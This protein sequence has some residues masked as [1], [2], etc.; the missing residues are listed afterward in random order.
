MSNSL[1]GPTGVVVNQV[2]FHADVPV[3]KHALL[4]PAPTLQYHW[5]VAALPLPLA[6][7]SHGVRDTVLDSSTL[8]LSTPSIHSPLHGQPSG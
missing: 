1:T 3:A 6:R 2:P 4:A 7:E 5:Q 8:D